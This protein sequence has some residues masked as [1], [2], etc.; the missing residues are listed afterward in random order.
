MLYTLYYIFIVQWYN[1][2]N[3]KDK[4]VYFFNV[5]PD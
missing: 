4:T 1:N 5:T 2:I 3:K